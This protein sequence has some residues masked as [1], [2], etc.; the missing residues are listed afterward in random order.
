VQQ[1]EK[2]GGMKEGGGEEEACFEDEWEGLGF[3]T[4]MEEEGVQ[5]VGHRSCGRGHLDPFK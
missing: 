4:G 1:K 5:G 2:G 3:G